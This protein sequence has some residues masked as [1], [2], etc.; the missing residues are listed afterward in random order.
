MR[1][2][3]FLQFI[4][5]PLWSL[6]QFLP[7]QRDDEYQVEVVPTAEKYARVYVVPPLQSLDADS[8]IFALPRV[9][10]GTYSIS[11]FGRFVDSLSVID[12][13]I[14]S[15]E[16][17]RLD[18][19]R[20]YIPNGKDVYRIS[21]RVNETLSR[22][23]ANIFEPSGT[24][25]REGFFWMNYF[26][27]VGY[28]LQA[29]DLP[30]ELTVQRPLNFYAA[31]NLPVKETNFGDDVFTAP[32]YFFLHDNPHLYALPDH[33]SVKVAN[34]NVHLA[35][36]SP[37]GINSAEEI[38]PAIA[39]LFQAAAD[40]F[41]GVLPVE[42]YHILLLLADV[43]SG[44]SYNYGAL[45][46]HYSTTVF[47][48]DLPLE[49]ILDNIR[50]IVAHEFLHIVT[51]LNFHSDRVHHFD[52]QFPRM[53]RHLWLY[54]G[55]TEYTSHL[56]QVRGGVTSPSDFLDEMRS[57][58]ATSA[59]YDPFVPIFTASKYAF[60]VHEDQYLSVYDKGALIAMMLDLQL[61]ISSNGEKD[62]KDL[63]V[64]LSN[65]YGPDTFFVDHEL[66][67]VIASH[68]FPEIHEFAARYIEANQPLPYR[69]FLDMV[70]YI[71][72]E[73]GETGTMSF[74]ITGF[75]RDAERNVLRVISMDEADAVALD[76]GYK[77]GDRIITLNGGSM[78]F[79][80]LENTIVQFFTTTQVGESI[81]VEVLRPNKK[82]TKFSTVRLRAT[83]K[84]VK[85]DA[86]NLITP[87]DQPSEARLKLQRK[88]LS[89]E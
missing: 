51:P 64:E 80:K 81:E 43:S 21:Y 49:Y 61:I 31:G 10:P 82:G 77:V 18:D 67:D 28:I 65:A 44:E 25:F 38:M 60:D 78:E 42:D 74:G 35:V 50:D 45:E 58:M 85:M 73:K 14:E 55:V 88:W 72:E 5:L 7:A 3:F 84:E 53:S 22:P 41:D 34:T 89:N 37:L 68:G 56:M 15:L 33:Q 2:F 36:H 20:W 30:F 13:H 86:P 8:V 63:M 27:I 47:M 46:H 17:I 54:E 4:L 9:V 11:S 39:D 87:M 6:A 79:G 70:G 66:F 12:Q 52:F 83:V 23:A 24:A 57:K 69:E 29:D 71:F 75:D 19:N 16:V 26:G 76:L 62:L 1:Q 48:P 32:N 59:D 40:Y